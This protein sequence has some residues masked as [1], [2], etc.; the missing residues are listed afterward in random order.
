MQLYTLTDIG[1]VRS[2]NQDAVDGG[3][4]H[5]HNAMWAVLCDGMGGANGGNVASQTAVEIA[6]DDIGFFD[7]YGGEYQSESF[8]KEIVY[9]ANSTVYHKQLKNPELSGMGTTMEL[10]F[11][12]NKKAMITHVGDSRVYLIHNN[13][14]T[15]LTVDHSVVQELVDRGKLTPQQAMVHPHKN[16]ITRAVGV[17]PYI[18]V[19]YIEAPFEEDDVIIMCSDGLSNYITDDGL[20]GFADKYKADDLT[21]KLIEHAKQLGGKDNITVAVL[22]AK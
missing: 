18:D 14:I 4:I 2:S 12:Y 9:K 7:F 11:V 20:L 8:L 3:I 5:D 21:N 22:Y 10:V 1:L 13:E 15:Q 16:F 19:D 17:H 6:K